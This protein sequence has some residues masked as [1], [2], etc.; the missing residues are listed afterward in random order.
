MFCMPSARPRQLNALPSP[1]LVSDRNI[2]VYTQTA[3]A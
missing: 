3:G 1:Q 2:H